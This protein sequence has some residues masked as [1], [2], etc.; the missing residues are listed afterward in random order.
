MK[1]NFRGGD[2][3]RPGG[4]MWP[5]MGNRQGCTGWMI[6]LALLF[7]AAPLLF[8]LLGGG[9]D[10]G[11]AVSYTQFRQ[12]VAAG[13]ISE[14]L[15]TGDRV[16]GQFDRPRLKQA[17]PSKELSSLPIYQPLKIKGCFHC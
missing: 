8:S 14:V 10:A 3:E 16:E 9:G 1:R 12:Q 17:P 11:Q 7:F 13:N 15:I 5:G 6:L 2:E 4:Q